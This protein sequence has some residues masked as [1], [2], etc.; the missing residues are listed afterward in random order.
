MFSISVF[1]VSLYLNV[2]MCFAY[3]EDEDLRTA[4][5]SLLRAL[6]QSPAAH[7]M[8]L[9]MMLLESLAESSLRT[10]TECS[11]VSSLFD[12]LLSSMSSQS[13][14][15]LAMNKQLT[16]WIIIKI[17]TNEACEVISWLRISDHVWKY[18]LHWGK[19]EKVVTI[20]LAHREGV[21]ASLNLYYTL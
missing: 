7:S 9:S 18:H 10:L 21:H 12:L 13:L 19:H 15:S 20:I 11:L 8:Q 2:D 3:S 4:V 14:V 16:E 1:I 17:Q 5:T 6:S